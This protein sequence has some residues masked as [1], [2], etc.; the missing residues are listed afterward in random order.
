[1]DH[2]S[3]QDSWNDMWHSTKTQ[4]HIPV[5]QF[6]LWMNL[7]VQTLSLHSTRH[8]LTIFVID[9]LSSSHTFLSCYLLLL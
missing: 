7:H 8:R 1:M 2:E 9:I 5:H 4:M 6:G 3:Q